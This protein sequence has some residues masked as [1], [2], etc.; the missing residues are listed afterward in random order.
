M[1]L[2]HV[3]QEETGDYKRLCITSS[4]G[5]FTMSTIRVMSG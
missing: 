3:L 2:I 4:P 5:E 1:T